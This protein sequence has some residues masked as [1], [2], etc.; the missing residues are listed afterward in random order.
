MGRKKDFNA[1]GKIAMT[2]RELFIE[3]GYAKTSIFTKEEV[4]LTCALSPFR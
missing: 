3:R 4:D 2:A 1:K